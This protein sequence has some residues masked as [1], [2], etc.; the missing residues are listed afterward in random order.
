MTRAR[1]RGWRQLIV[2]LAVL[3]CAGTWAASHVR[4]ARDRSEVAKMTENMKTVCVGRFLVDVP[5]TAEIG[6]SHERVAGFAIETVQESEDAFRQRIGAREAKIAARGPATDGTGG[7]VEARDLRIAG[8]TGRTLVYGL[9]RGYYMAGDRR[10]DDEYVSVEAHGHM[11]G[12]SFSLSAEFGDEA[13]AA[14]A[15][16]MLARLRL[17]GA[18]EI[19]AVA[20]FCIEAA[21]FAEPLPVRKAEHAALHMGMPGHPDLALAFSAMAGGR[22][23]RSL[24]TRVAENDAEAPP[25]EL[26][27]V[28]KLRAS[29][30][31]INGLPGEELLER[32]RELNFT[33]GYNFMWEMIGVKNDPL[34][35]YLLLQMETGTNPRAGGK[36]VD[37]TL[38]EDALV[39]LWDRISS[40]IRVRPSSSPDPVAAPEP[41]S[42][43]LG[44]AARAGE[45]CPHSGWWRCNEGGPGLDVHGGAVQYL[46]K[47]EQ[48]RQALLLPRQTVWQKLRGIQPSTE[49]TQPT[50]WKLVDRRQRPRTPVLV[51]LV[52]A[53]GAS[54]APDAGEGADSTTAIGSY[55][56]TGEVCPESGWWR[57]DETHALDGT[58]WFARGAVLPAATF[59]V[60]SGLFGRSPGPDVI[61]RRST[62][63]LVRRAEAEI[64]AD[65]K[66]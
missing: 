2:L 8:M 13:R 55:A 56:R 12:Y 3:A 27:R 39:A 28:T 64:G 15:E 52:P 35:P 33:T 6:M 4:S 46:R 5:A 45:A 25:D 31:K 37:S 58:R 32:V 62:W 14:L 61:Q 57:C 60:P 10:I 50:V 49:P 51:T 41:P 53:G 1:K 29:N 18:D 65:G 23:R 16:A 20:G 54:T 48:M 38:H 36:P 7:L 47:G 34:R 43:L 44:T 9:N 63:Q 40:S 22:E 24:L 11:G 66:L 19:P 30:R 21:V 26:L 42:P 17:R 59:Q